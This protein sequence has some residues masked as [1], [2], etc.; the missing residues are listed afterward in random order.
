MGGTFWAV[1]AV[2]VVACSSDEIH[3]RFG[4][5]NLESLTAVTLVAVA[6]RLATSGDLKRRLGNDLV[7]GI[8]TARENLASVAVADY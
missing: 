5:P 2:D 3:G 4:L 6:A 1:V 8:G 7:H